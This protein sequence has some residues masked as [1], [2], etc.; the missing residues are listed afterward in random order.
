MW[1]V[2]TRTPKGAYKEAYWDLG[3]LGLGNFF[4][5]HKFFALW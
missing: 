1:A 5:T 3:Q 4:L 2:T